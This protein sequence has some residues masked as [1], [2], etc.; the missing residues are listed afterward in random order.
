MYDVDVSSSVP[1][2]VME[3]VETPLSSLLRDVGN[4]V[5]VR[6]RVDLAF[7]IVCALEYFH[8][9]LRVTQWVTA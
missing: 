3:K 2:L 9:H 7:G 6:E 1:M 8:V 5:T 4:M